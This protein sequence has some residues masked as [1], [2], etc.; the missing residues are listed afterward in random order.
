MKKIK[1]TFKIIRE[2]WKHPKYHALIMLGFYFL[3]FFILSIMIRTSKNREV[4][5]PKI[6]NTLD[7]YTM[8]TS[9]EYDVNILLNDTD[10][11]SLEGIKYKEINEFEDTITKNKYYFLDNQIMDKT[12]SEEIKDARFFINLNS[13]TVNNLVNILKNNKETKELKYNDGA[14]KKEYIINNITFSDCF[15]ETLNIE[16]NEKNNYISN[17]KLN[18]IYNNN[19]YNVEINYKNI[20]NIKSYNSN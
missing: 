14:I 10:K 5:E 2:L 20:N 11:V 1:E 7:N 13:I 9:Y 8:M 3:F 6:V 17:I 12:T 19:I 18:F 16:T 15:I 4:T